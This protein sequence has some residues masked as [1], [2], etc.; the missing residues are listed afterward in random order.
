MAGE[1]CVGLLDHGRCVAAARAPQQALQA[2]PIQDHVALYAR[3]LTLWLRAR[4][5]RVVPSGLS[6]GLLQT[7]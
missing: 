1:S 2:S 3:S 6:H 7:F 5:P 4:N